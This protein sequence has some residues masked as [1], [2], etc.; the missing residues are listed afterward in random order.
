MVARHAKGDSTRMTGWM[1]RRL[2]GSR[3]RAVRTLLALA[4]RL[5]GGDAD[6]LARMLHESQPLGADTLV[7]AYA[8]GLFPMAQD[9]G[10]RVL[11]FDPPMRAVLP[12]DG[13]RI[14]REARRLA[15]QGRFAVT[16]DTAFDQVVA[17]CA[18]HPDRR[19]DTWISDGLMWAYAELHRIGAAHSVEVWQEGALVGGLY[20]V[21]IG[22]YFAGESQ[23]RLVNN[24]GAVG[25][26]H[27]CASLRRSGFLLHDVQYLKPHLQ[28]MGAFEITREEFRRRLA[29]AIVRPV[30]LRLAA[31]VD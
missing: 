21:A 8:C 12:V 11:W 30:T 19:H 18:H 31:A 9:D 22:G 13:V 6:A 10:R 3:H 28:R 4:R 14:G 25:F 29:E 17:H 27:L 7:R 23:F 1:R 15:R 16:M 26:A 5:Q 20:G 2:R 24:A